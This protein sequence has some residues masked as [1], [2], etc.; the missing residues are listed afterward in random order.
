VNRSSELAWRFARCFNGVVRRLLAI[1]LLVVFG[2]PLVSPLFALG[3]I[4]ASLP[5]CCRRAGKHQCEMSAEARAALSQHG[6]MFGAQ[7]EKCP[8]CPA[9]VGVRIGNTLA[10]PVGQAVYAALVAHPSG[11]VQTES[12]LRVSL[13][14]SRQKRG[15]PAISL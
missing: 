13:G 11:V 8:Y 6:P 1:S 10:A 3:A 2:L 5:A 4:G 12:K 15:P 9:S 14:R 7:V